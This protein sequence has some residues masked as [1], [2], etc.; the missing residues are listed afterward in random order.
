[1]GW[2]LNGRMGRV[3]VCGYFGF[4]NNSYHKFIL[5][6]NKEIFVLV[7]VM[8]TNINHMSVAKA[9]VEKKNMLPNYAILTCC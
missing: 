3:K 8:K 5:R 4:L 7:P 9:H 1:M 6:I 2:P